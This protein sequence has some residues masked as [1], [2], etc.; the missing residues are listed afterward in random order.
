MVTFT[1]VGYSDYVPKPGYRLLAVSGAF[2]TA[3]FGVVLSRKVIR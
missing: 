3:F 2:L 1:T